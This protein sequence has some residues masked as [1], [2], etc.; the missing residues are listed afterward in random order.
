MPLLLSSWRLSGYEIGILRRS[1]AAGTPPADVRCAVTNHR[2]QHVKSRRRLAA[3]LPPLLLVVAAV[4]DVPLPAPGRAL[5]HQ[6]LGLGRRLPLD[7]GL[8]F[9]VTGE[10][11]GE[12]R[13][14][15]VFGDPWLEQL[16]LNEAADE[17]L[18][19]PLDLC[20]RRPHAGDL[21]TTLSF[22]K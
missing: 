9:E 12:A 3:E 8:L 21:D 1:P 10:N 2:A 13:A 18:R 11:G 7:L 15:R 20:G 22:C 19:H 14:D 5:S 16:G 17:S 6:S 4:E